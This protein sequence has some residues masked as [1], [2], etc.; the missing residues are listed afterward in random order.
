M[1][2]F[3]KPD[4]AGR[5]QAQARTSFAGKLAAPLLAVATAGCLCTASAQVI[6]T[7][8][9][10]GT[11]AFGGDGGAAVAAKLNFPSNMAVDKAGNLYFADTANHRIRKVDAQTGI[12]TTVAG[13]GNMAFAGDGGPA[14]DASLN[15]PESVA[16]DQSDVLYIADTGNSR[17]RRVNPGTPA[18][19]TTFAGNGSLGFAGDNAAASQATLY[20]P[21]GVAVSPNGE[22]YISDTYNHRIRVVNISGNISTVAGNGTAGSTGD[23]GAPGAA[24]LYYPQGIAFTNSGSL[25]VADTYNHRIR[26]IGTTIIETVAGDG[27]LGFG[28]DGGPARSAKLNYPVTVAANPDGGF[29][30]AD[31]ANDRIRVVSPSGQIT[32]FAGTGSAGFSGDCGVPTSA[33]LN[34]PE[35]VAVGVGGKVYLSDN[36]NHRIRLVSITSG[37]IDLAVAQSFSPATAST[38][39]DLVVRLVVTSGGPACATGIRVSGTL[40]AGTTWIW[41]SSGCSQAGGSF[42]CTLPGL[43]PGASAESKIV[44]R[45]S[46]A[47]T[48]TSIVSVASDQAESAPA[49][50]TS[51]STVDVSTSSSAKFIQRYRLYSPVTLEHH[52]TT[53]PIEYNYLG[54]LVGSWNQEGVDGNLLDNP[55]SLNG[56]NAVPYYRLYTPEKRWHHWTTDPNEYYTLSQWPSWD[57]EGIDGYILPS[58][59][60]GTTPLYRLHYPAIPGLHHWTT[61]ALEA[62]V[63]STPERG[64]VIEGIDHILK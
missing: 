12:I 21:S 15:F 39:K 11:R 43:A 52:F 48:L 49:N 9:G 8:A 26:G 45:P 27:T 32:T 38:G 28:G 56:I 22:V 16:L 17:I 37:S 42:S 40:P 35:A 61:D 33:N 5:P 53:N 64:W 47:G 30:I 13:S 24:T 59:T 10:D 46:T 34:Y 23:G 1:L 20:Y 54:T 58:A 6:S 14:T 57:G 2:L 36:E 25:L 51:T 55:G 63:L 19:I 3:L 41:G 62:S 7:W 60:D 18:V 29:Y 4:A 44:L 31:S 50:N